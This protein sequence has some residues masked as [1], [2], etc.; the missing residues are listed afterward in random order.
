[1]RQNSSLNEL[2][3]FYLSKG[4]HN[5]LKTALIRGLRRDGGV[6]DSE[7]GRVRFLVVE[8]HYPIGTRLHVIAL[9]HS[10]LTTE[11]SYFPLWI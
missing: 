6:S 1:M 5:G 11:L 9:S 8:T 7:S 10:A 2:V 4:N 3:E